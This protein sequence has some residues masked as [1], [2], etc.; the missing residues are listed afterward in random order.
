MN[1]QLIG[2]NMQPGSDHGVNVIIRI[3]V[4][5]KY[6]FN[7]HSGDKKRDFGKTRADTARQS[8]SA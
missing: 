2:S 5:L 1:P 6:I 3:Q 4:K 7:P 8:V